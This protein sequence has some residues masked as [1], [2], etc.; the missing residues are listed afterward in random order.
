MKL[1]EISVL[2]SYKCPVCRRR[3]LHVEK[4]GYVTCHACE[5]FGVLKKSKPRYHNLPHMIIGDTI[6]AVK[7]K[8]RTIGIVVNNEF[9]RINKS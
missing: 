7:Q 4:L 8:R 9:V 5:F 6:Y 1:K 2:A 3:H